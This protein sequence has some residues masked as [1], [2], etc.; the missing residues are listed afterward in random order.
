MPCSCASVERMSEDTEPPRCVWS[1]A[2]PSIESVYSHPYDGPAPSREA[3]AEECEPRR[4][5]HVEGDPYADDS[6]AQLEREDRERDEHRAGNEHRPHEVARVAGSDEDPVEHED[7]AAERLHQREI[8]PE[9]RGFVE[10][11]GVA[12]ECTRHNMRERQ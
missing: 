8:R 5:Q 11:S 1:S 10:H 2:R 7:R 6:P 12:G 4:D 3:D 9:R